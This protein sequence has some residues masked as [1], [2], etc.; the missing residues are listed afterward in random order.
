MPDKQSE[1][2]IIEIGQTW[3]EGS[4]KMVSLRLTKTMEMVMVVKMTNTMMLGVVMMMMMVVKLT[5]MM[6]LGDGAGEDCN[7][8]S[9]DWSS[10]KN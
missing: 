9:P 1:P 8:Y 4:V 7:L 2:R 5:N 6:M 3:V 10:V